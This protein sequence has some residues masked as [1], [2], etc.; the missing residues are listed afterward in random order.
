MDKLTHNLP[1][2]LRSVED[3][4]GSTGPELE[5]GVLKAMASLMDCLEGTGQFNVLAS[6]ISSVTY[7]Q[8]DRQQALNW[9]LQGV[10]H[11]WELASN[12]EVAMAMAEKQDKVLN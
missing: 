9:L 3:L 10:V 2:V 11:G 1:L 5:Q 8:S 4:E 6:L 12:M 7:L